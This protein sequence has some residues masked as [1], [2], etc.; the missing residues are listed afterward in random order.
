MRLF[1]ILNFLFISPMALA[2][3]QVEFEWEEVLGAKMYQVEIKKQNQVIQNLDSKSFTF[4][5]N[6][7]PGKYQ[8]RG[9]VLGVGKKNS[10]SEWSD[11]KDFDIPPAKIIPKPLDKYEYQP[12]TKSYTAQIG[13]GWQP[14]EGADK[15][16]I[17]IFDEKNQLKKTNEIKDSKTMI[18]LRPGNYSVKLTALTDDGLTS[19]PTFLEKPIKVQ[20]ILIPPPRKVELFLKRRLLRFELVSGT[21]ALLTLQ[22]QDFLG[23]EWQEIKIPPPEENYFR[24]G[25]ELRPGKYRFTLQSRNLFDEVSKPI[26]K[27]FEIKPQEKDLPP[28]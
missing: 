24:W 8:I 20:N 13:I 28:N 6:I 5:T 25:S 26:V 15:Y 4:K 11:W 19:E 27:E 7:R 3:R 18:Q 21:S 12:E 2:N 14:I 9:R 17:E 1:F 23:E 22:R 10:E 16:R